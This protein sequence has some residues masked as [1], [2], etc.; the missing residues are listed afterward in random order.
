MIIKVELKSPLVKLISSG[1]GVTGVSFT[2]CYIAISGS[3]IKHIQ[4]NDKAMNLKNE[5]TI[6]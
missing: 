6:Y 3:N 5:K 2:C 1:S 4:L